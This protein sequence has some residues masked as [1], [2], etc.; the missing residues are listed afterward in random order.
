MICKRKFSIL[1]LAIIIL[2]SFFYINSYSQESKKNVL[3]LCS[4][5]SENKWEHSIVEEVKRNLKNINVKVDFLDSTSSDSDIYNESF[6]KLLN[7]KYKNEDIDCILT[8]DDEALNFARHNLFNKDF[9][10][11]KKP[12]VFVGVNGYISL[13]SEEENYITGILEYQDNL[14]FLDTILNLNSDVKN[15]CLLLNNSI[16]SNMIKKNISHLTKFTS[17]PFSMCTIE[18]DTFEDIKDKINKLDDSYAII[19]CVTYKDFA[20]GE[21]MNE[22]NIIEEIKKVTDVPIY[23]KLKTYV[24]A[25]AIGGIVNDESKLGKIAAVFLEETIN[26]EHKEMVTPTYSTFNTAIFNFQSLREYNIDPLLLPKNSVII[27]KGTFDL[28]VPRYLEIIIWVSI[29]LVI[30]G[31]TTLIYMYS[32]NKKNSLKDKLLLRKSIEKDE[33]KTDFIIT[34]SHELRTPLNIIINANKLLNLKVYNDKYEKEFFQKQINL[35]NKNSNRLLRLINNLIDVSKIEVGYVDATFKNENIV[36]V[37]EDVTMS[38]IDLANSYNIEIIFDTEEEEI[39]TAIDRSKIE[40]IMLNLLS[41]SIKFT[42][43]G[44][45]I[46]VNLKKAGKD[47]IIEVKDDGIGMSNDTKD[48]L[49]EKFKKAKRYPSLEREHEGSGLGLFIVKG[50]V[51]IHNG[52]INVESEI[53]KGTKFIIKIPQGFV[54]KENSNQNLMNVPLDYTSKIELSDIYNK[55]E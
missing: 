50:L 36:D 33:I 11:Y 39:I 27:N 43:D 29:L 25:G 16:Y 9:F 8:I 35:I 7:I 48:H 21:F 17:R 32:S 31:I 38:V 3:I 26:G 15:I 37:V 1:L 41:N 40:R 55:D 20:D 18:S 4:Y 44:G 19:V 23:S 12:I 28:L 30:L 13:S 42:N 14:F 6:M 2:I 49:F 10:M 46:Y 53:N 24:E 47:I 34:M 51:G 5:N 45:H 54:D 52:S 22:T